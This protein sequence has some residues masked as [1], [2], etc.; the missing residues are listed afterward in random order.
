MFDT[1]AHYDFN[2][3]DPWRAQLFDELS[4]QGVN[5]VLIPGVSLSRSVKQISVAKQ[6]D[7]YYALGMHP[8]YLPKDIS[9]SLVKLDNL[10]SEQRGDASLV[11]LGECGLDKLVDGFDK[12]VELFEGQLALAHQ[13][14]LPVILHCVRAHEEVLAR[15]KQQN[16]AKAGVVHGFYG[17]TE[18]AKRYISLGYKL[19]I[20][21]L[22][23]RDNAKKLQ[24]A[25]AHIPLEHMVVETDNVKFTV[26]DASD[27]PAYCQ[28][29]QKITTKIANLQNLPTVF[30][31]E[32]LVRNSLQLLEV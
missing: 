24:E 7:C 17:S 25:V 6:F 13:Y 3:F 31:V 16:L 21:G 4:K 12:Q 1:H 9:Q 22:L 26:Q 27:F 10:L 32:Q 28:K 5:K 23:L 30:V 14:E 8:W 11:A 19:G 15:L 18:L 29:I 20:G 2:D